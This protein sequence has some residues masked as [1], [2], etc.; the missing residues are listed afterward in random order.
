M[1]VKLPII[2]EFIV[3]HLGK[4][5]EAAKNITVPF[6]EYINN[7]ASSEI[8]PTWPVD[9][10]KANILAQISFALNRVYNEWYP[11]K[12][13]NFDITS[14]PSYDQTFIE[15]RQFFETIVN[16][17]D[18]IFNDYIRRDG[19]IQPLYA[20]YCD[21]KKTTCNGLSQWGSVELAKNGKTPMEILRYYYGNDINLVF[22]A[23]IA[24]NLLSYPGFPLKVGTSGDFVRIIKLQLNRISNNY[25]AIPKIPNEDIYFRIGME[26]SVKKFQEI[27]NLPVTGIVDKGTWYKIKYIYNSVKKISDLYSEGITANEAELLLGD[28]LKEGDTGIYVRTL[29]YLLSVIAYFDQDIPFYNINDVYN[30]DVKT[31]VIAFQN[32]YGLEPT[33]IIDAS[34][35]PKLKTVYQTTI[36]TIPEE[37]F[38]YID[39]F[40]PGIFLSK[41]MSGEDV[42]RLQNFLYVI[43]TKFKNIPGVRVDGVF[44]SLTE[45]S[46][47]AIQKQDNLPI[48]GIVGPTTWYAI[49]EMSKK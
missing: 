18:D 27:F 40:Y 22:N 15:D 32:K 12:G 39:E 9:A 28:S 36:D 47:K 44:D 16:I 38:V 2:P 8:Y 17:V 24:T 13:Y 14:L 7:V 25:P 19:Q 46:V 48:T 5:D 10:I 26:D 11:S 45:S 35:W 42:R 1:A 34:T 33:G 29:S 30:E 20:Q 43:C 4:P 41:G 49:V 31:M 6:Q 23:P 3:V 21:G 37:Y